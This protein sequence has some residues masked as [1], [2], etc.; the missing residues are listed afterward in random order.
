M[1]ATGHLPDPGTA[2]RCRGRPHE[3]TRT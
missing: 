2:P 3:R 1:T